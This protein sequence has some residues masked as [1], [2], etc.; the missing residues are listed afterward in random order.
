MRRS[1]NIR[2]LAHLLRDGTQPLPTCIDHYPRLLS[3]S[4]RGLLGA[5]SFDDVW[6]ADTNVRQC[7]AHLQRDVMVMVGRRPTLLYPQD[8]RSYYF[9]TVCPYMDIYWLSPNTCGFVLWWIHPGLRRHTNESNSLLIEHILQLSAILLKILLWKIY[10]V[11]GETIGIPQNTAAQ[12]Q[13]WLADQPISL[14]LYDL[15]KKLSESWTEPQGSMHASDHPFLVDAIYDHSPPSRDRSS[16]PVELGLLSRN[17]QQRLPNTSISEVA[18]QWSDNYKSK[19]VNETVDRVPTFHALDDESK[20]QEIQ[21]TCQIHGAVFA[22]N[23][24]NT[25]IASGRFVPM[26]GEDVHDQWARCWKQINFEKMNR[27]SHPRSAWLTCRWCGKRHLRVLSDTNSIVD[28]SSPLWCPAGSHLTT[29]WELI[30]KEYPGAFPENNVFFL[31]YE[32]LRPGIVIN[33]KQLAAA[34][35]SFLDDNKWHPQ[36]EILYN[37]YYAAQGL[38]M[39]FESN[40]A[41]KALISTFVAATKRSMKRLTALPTPAIIQTTKRYSLVEELSGRINVS[42]NQTLFGI[43]T[44]LEN[45]R[46]LVSLEDL[47]FLGYRQHFSVETRGVWYEG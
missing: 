7:I 26:E 31:F 10:V 40:E 47:D 39:T 35:M 9:T 20:A 43:K 14:Q 45:D 18:R 41:Q 4:Y 11:S 3:D 13:Q 16:N 23:Y 12:L 34:F 24:L 27:S 28:P 15:L 30:D 17:I 32:S 1:R 25:C 42:S 29:G 19:V 21:L 37:R 33:Q 22:R 46:S 5:T 36:A 44:C 2:F 6:E 8:H 38:I